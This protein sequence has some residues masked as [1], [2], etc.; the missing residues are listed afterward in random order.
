MKRTATVFVAAALGVTMLGACSEG[1]SAPGGGTEVAAPSF[2]AEDVA[3]AS[4]L[5]QIEGHHIVAVE[6]AEADDMTGAQV[7][8]HHPIDELMA[9]IREEVAEHAEDGDAHVA[10]LDEQTQAAADAANAEDAEALTSATEET[11]TTIETAQAALP[12][13]DTDA[14][15]GSVT[16]DLLTTAGHEY[17]EAVVDG[18]L[19]LLVEYQDAYAFVTVARS[20]YDTIAPSV[21][22]AAA[23]E[24]EEIEAAFATLAEALPGPQ[25]P[26]TLADADDVAAAA[27]LI[28][29]E[30][31]ET[32]GALVPETSDAAEVWAN[33]HTLLDEI[34]STYEGGDP[35]EAAELAAEAYLENYELVEAS[36][37]EAAPDV[38]AEL[39]PL[40][41]ADL[42]AQIAAGITAEEL[43][44]MIDRARELIGEAMEATGAETDH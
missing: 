1:S 35:D 28:A 5:R 25:P 13:G 4:A 41:G 15:V 38:N 39:E 2:S 9:L 40:L 27:A 20:L 11:A 23:E 14:F 10:D 22:A 17:E 37:I 34:Q 43:G 3:T 7:H 44:V 12:E 26:A 29:H 31:E 32:V 42:R 6:L 18:E 16:A 24:A 36:V 19:E 30:L 33:I 21:E 8:A